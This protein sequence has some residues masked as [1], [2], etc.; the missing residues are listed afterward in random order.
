MNIEL[1]TASKTS[2]LEVLDLQVSLRPSAGRSLLSVRF[3]C[4][5]E[6]HANHLHMPTLS[7]YDA[8]QL[9]QFSQELATARF[10][11]TCQTDLTEAGLRL[12]GSVRRLAGRWTTGRTIKVEPLPSA[13]S[14]FAPFTIHASHL[15]VT[16]YAQKLYN[17]LWEVFTRA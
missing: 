7:W 16:T 8:H 6:T 17:R 3:L 9:Q 5:N 13:P 10:P 11:E 1:A 4:R 12:T 15:D 14:Q 2:P